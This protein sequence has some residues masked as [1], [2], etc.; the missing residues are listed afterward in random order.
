MIKEYGENFLDEEHDPEP[1]PR[2]LHPWPVLTLPEHVAGSAGLG[3][4]DEG[5][6]DNHTQALCRMV[7]KTPDPAT[8]K[9]ICPNLAS[10]EC[11]PVMYCPPDGAE[12]KHTI[13]ELTRP[14]LASLECCPVRCCPANAPE[15]PGKFFSVLGA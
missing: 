8:R 9:R 14:T 2:R 7:D 15:K 11:C 13:A 4:I 1:E 6:D 5:C 12:T 10:L 3:Y